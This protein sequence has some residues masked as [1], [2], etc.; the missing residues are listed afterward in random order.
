MI[1]SKVSGPYKL[2]GAVIIQKLMF[3]QLV[4]SFAAFYGTC[5]FVFTRANFSSKDNRQWTRRP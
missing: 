1:D 3:A 5:V 2:L 4:K